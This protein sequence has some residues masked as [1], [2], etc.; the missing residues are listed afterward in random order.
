MHAA[1]ILYPDAAFKI[2]ILETALL[3]LRSILLILCLLINPGCTEQQTMPAVLRIGILPDESEA[4]LLKRYTPLFTYLSKKLNIPYEVNIPGNY[5]ELVDDFA[6]HKI[7]LAYFGGFTFIKA[8]NKYGAIPLVMRD[9]D[10]RFTSYF[11]VKKEMRSNDL[12]DFK[13]KKF[14]FGSRLSTSGHLMPR[15]F[16]QEKNIIPEKYFSQV[17]Y[18]GAHDK[19]VYL[20]R[21]GKVELGVANANIYNNMLKDGRVKKS[22]VRILWETPPYPDYVWALR[23]EFGEDVQ[24]KIKNAFLYLSKSEPQHKEILDNINA[25]GFLPASINDFKQLVDV[26]KTVQL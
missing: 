23:A 1:I 4:R 8:Y 6:K 15:Y 7:D 18:S 13:N 21:D 20:V 19:T 9:I 11:L 17:L 24:N 16:L 5:A 14:S 10:V 2:Y 22:E 26:I 3:A 12:E 25:G